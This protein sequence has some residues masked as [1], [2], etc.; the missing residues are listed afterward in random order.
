MRHL[1]VAAAVMAAPG[2]VS[3][4]RAP[5]DR[6]LPSGLAFGVEL[7]EPSSVTVRFAPGAGRIGGVAAVGTGTWFGPGLSVRAE[8]TYAAAT[9]AR[10]ARFAVPL[11]VGIGVRH[12]RHHYAPASMDELPDAHTSV[13]ASATLALAFERVELYVEAA[14]GYDLARTSSCSLISGASSVCPHAQESDLFVELFAGAR[15][16]LR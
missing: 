8:A 4:D 15:W 11:H 1:F 12:H 13:L 6:P 5:A 3:A 16:Y 9:L 2:P 7:G 10:R 14:P